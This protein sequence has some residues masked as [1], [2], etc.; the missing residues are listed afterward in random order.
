MPEPKKRNLLRVKRIDTIGLVDRGDNPEADI[1]IWKRDPKAVDKKAETFSEQ[2][3]QND[4]RHEVYDM[5][6]RMSRALHGAVFE[7]EEGQD[8][9]AIINASLEQFTAAVRAAAPGWLAGKPVREHQGAVVMAETKKGEKFDVAKLDEAARAEFKRLEDEASALTKQVGDLTTKVAD[10]EKNVPPPPKDVLKGLTPEA[11]AEVET[12]LKKRD[13][14]NDTLRK[15]HEALVA[16]MDRDAMAIRF[17]KGGDLEGLSGDKRT[18]LVLAA[19]KAMSAEDFTA[20]DTML[21]ATAEQ[22]R[23]GGLFKELGTG[24]QGEGK[25]AW[26]EIQAKAAEMVT[27]GEAPTL[28]QAVDKVVRADRALA[29]RYQDEQKAR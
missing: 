24:A 6:D 4:V 29:K 25:T 3:K 19:K 21:R 23:T 12:E 22:I 5:T 8:P 26:D 28:E 2:G 20:L 1:L 7:A 18:D 11:R 15:S 9:A 17:A 14:A 10:L 27:K 13:E 16:K